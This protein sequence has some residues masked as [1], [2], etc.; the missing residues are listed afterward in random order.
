LLLPVNPEAK[1]TWKQVPD[2]V[3]RLVASTLGADVVEAEQAW[4]GFAPSATFR[5]RLADGR[6]AFFKGAG[7]F[8]N[9]HMRWALAREERVY[10]EVG[11]PRPNW[12]EAI[13]L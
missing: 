12:I 6:R 10:R 3:R 13:V 4:G 9:D 5:L 8:A 2:G 7:D 1:P 11:L